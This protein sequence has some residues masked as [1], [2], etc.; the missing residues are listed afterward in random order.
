[1]TSP[2]HPRP[3]SHPAPAGHPEPAPAQSQEL[4]PVKSWAYPFATNSNKNPPVT[5]D[6][7][8]ALGSAG[9][10]FYPLGANGIWH[11]G[12]HFDELTAGQLKQ[13]D[14]VRAIADG[15]VIAYRLDSQYPEIKYVDDHNARYSTGFVLIRHKLALPPLPDAQKKSGGASKASPPAGDVL[16]FY[17]LYMHLLDLDGYTTAE[18]SDSSASTSAIQAT[19]TI[20][21]MKYWKGDAFYRAGAK[22]IDKQRPLVASGGSTTPFGPTAPSDTGS[23]SGPALLFGPG[24]PDTVATADTPLVTGLHIYD[25]ANGKIL[26]L[27]PRGSE[28]KIS[29]A[30]TAGWGTISSISKGA[31][32]GILQGSD[33]DAGA[34]TGWVRLEGLDSLID[35]SPLDAVVLLDKPFRVKAGDLV[36]YLGQYVSHRYSNT[37][38]ASSNSRPLLHLEVFAGDTLPAFLEKSRERAKKLSD[39]EKELLVVLPGA[40]LVDIA[41]AV[42]QTVPAGLVLEPVASHSGTGPWKQVQ[43]T[44]ITAAPHPSKGHP[45]Q[46]P[47]KT[48]IGEPLWVDRALAGHI[49]SDAGGGNGIVHGWT[50]FPLQLSNAKRAPVTFMDVFTPSQLARLDADHKAVDDEGVKWWKIQ[51]GT[52]SGQSVEGWVCDSGHPQTERQS[53]WAW[54]GFELVDGTSLKV[55]DVF[56][57]SITVS[58]LALP[59]EESSF[60]ASALTVNQSELF[61]KLETAIDLDGNGTVTAQELATAHSTPWLAEALSHLIVRYESEW[62]GGTAKWEE[63]TPLMKERAPVWA[64]EVERIEKLQWWDQANALK[65]FPRD[66]SIYHIHPIGLIGNFA[67]IGFRFALDMLL[68]LFPNANAGLLQE[69]ANELNAHIDFYE[70]DTPLRRTH[71]FAQVMQEAGSG[72]TVEEG[73]VWKASALTLFKYFREHPDEAKLHGYDKK[74]PIKAD[75]TPMNQSDFEAIANGAYGGRSELGNGDYA[76]GDGW[77]FRGRGLKQLT[78]RA[79]YHDFSAWH[80]ANQEQ[81]PDDPVDFEESPDLLL[82]MKYAARSAAY[83]WVAHKLAIKADRGADAGTVDSITAVVN[84]NTK[85]YGDRVNNFNFICERKVFE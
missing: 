28:L 10:G 85:S 46:K 13:D 82:Q 6:Y 17:S 71:F 35:P 7:L 9:G 30:P 50:Q 21:R 5:R 19:A 23:A 79:N 37:L 39:G 67:D 73:F 66:P 48:K 56:K 11:G 63:L 80:K 58:G 77:K 74:R 65:A 26:G 59:D 2:K 27:L 47:A 33:P 43:P 45:H 38:P 24:A 57:R 70:L 36:G 53:P 1:M 78:G 12:I 54:P 32:V 42:S 15:E 20:R 72:L 75:G 83:F 84:L 4:A 40:A 31:P 44:R 18:K 76:S 55:D 49:V 41:P 34:S 8:A 68:L 25:K 81:W 60:Q 69:I 52:G 29:P 51:V 16:D 22:A 3:Q 62:G 61:K 64:M 14:G